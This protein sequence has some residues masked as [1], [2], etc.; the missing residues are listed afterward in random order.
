MCILLQ[1]L[2]I[3]LKNKL[4]IKQICLCRS[5]YIT[6][7][8]RNYIPHDFGKKVEQISNTKTIALPQLQVRVCIRNTYEYIVSGFEEK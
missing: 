4:K 8:F 6:V 1:A 3:S 5:T 2:F 7:K